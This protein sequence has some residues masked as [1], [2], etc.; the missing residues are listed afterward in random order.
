MSTRVQ[1]TPFRVRY[2]ETD[3]QGI[4]HHSAYVVWLEMGRVEWLREA[5]L[6]YAAIEADGYSLP[7]IELRLRYVNAARFDQPLI[8]RTALSDLRS[9]SLRFTYEVVT[10]EAQPR[11][12]ANGSSEHFCLERGRI[13][14]LP[15][16]LLE[17][18]ES[19]LRGNS[20][21]KA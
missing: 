15:A 19:E 7:V 1:S 6:S 14:K 5:G 18:C 9:R 12:V 16:R 3:A 13:T 2:A 11:Q 20:D 17:L 8:V 21:A 10:D 4:A